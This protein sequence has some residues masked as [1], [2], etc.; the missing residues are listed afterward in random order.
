MSDL[1]PLLDGSRVVIIGGGPGGAACG[2][3]VMRL[4]IASGRRIQVT[5]V[6]GKEFTAERHYNQCLGVLSPPL[7]SLLENDLGVPFPWQLSRGEIREYVLHSEHE[8]L[9]LHGEHF[10]SVA[11]RRVNFDAYMLEAAREHGV[12]LL[13]ARAVDLEFRA[14]DLVVYTESAPVEADVVV[15]AFGMDDGSAAVFERHSGYRR[16]A[17]LDTLVTKVHPGEDAMTRFGPRIHAFLPAH[18]RIEFAAVTPKGNH[19]SIALAGRRIDS[20]LM[21][22][23]LAQPSTRAHL[24]DLERAGQWDPNDLRFFKGRF[25]RTLA[26]GYY[27]DRYVM[28]GDAAG[29]VRAFK[30]KGVT[31]AVQTGIRAAEAMLQ[32]GISAQAFQDQYRASNQEIIDGLPYGRMMRLVAIALARSGLLDRVLRAARADPRLQTALFDA[33]SGRTTYREVLQNSLT[34]S[35]VVAV[36]RSVLLRRGRTKAADELG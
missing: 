2:L 12:D 27:G 23:F 8:Q 31:A 17:F 19:L 18:P 21:R 13:P 36:L 30:G 10:P 22:G 28:V 33:V 29:L 34:L 1:G 16:P 20:R 9:T 25:P 7:P 11:L 35:S 5:I 32:A 6:E 4:A 15:G 3:A 26:R 14:D 24:P